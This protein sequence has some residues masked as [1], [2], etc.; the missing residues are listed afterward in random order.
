[1]GTLQCTASPPRWGHPLKVR[2][3]FFFG[4]NPS[5][6][7]RAQAVSAE[8]AHALSARLDELR[9]AELFAQHESAKDALAGLPLMRRLGLNE[10]LFFL[11]SHWPHFVGPALA[12]HSVPWSLKEGVLKVQADGPLHRQEL[13]Y[14]LARVLRTARDHLGDQVRE[15]EVLR[16]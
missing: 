13:A 15:V 12:A 3:A 5:R 11:R 8:R 7:P 4:S 10:A 9:R 6:A 2:V 16:R 1:M 14:S